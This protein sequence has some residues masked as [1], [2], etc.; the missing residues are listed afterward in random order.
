MIE[1]RRVQGSDSCKERYN[2]IKK[3]K[4]RVTRNEKLK[5]NIGITLIKMADTI[6]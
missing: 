2:K 1:S 3:I 4:F 5:R 6:V